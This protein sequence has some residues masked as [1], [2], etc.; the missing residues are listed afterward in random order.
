VHLSLVLPAGTDRA[1]GP[2]P[3]GRHGLSPRFVRDHQR[4]RIL[5]ATLEV[6]GDSGFQALTVDQIIAAAGVSRR[7]FYDHFANRDAAFVAAY[8]AVVDRVLAHV[9]DA[10]TEA[11]GFADRL[12]RGLEALVD[13]LVAEPAIARAVVVEVLAS[14]APGPA[15]RDKV[16]RRFASMLDEAAADTPPG[17]SRPTSPLTASTVVGGINEVVATRLVRGHAA[18]LPSLVPDLVYS[19]LLPYVGREAA[20]AE[21]RRLA[22]RA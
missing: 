16:L 20:A 21:H 15:R 7:T 3:A 2:L 12:H 18:E 19:A 9:G 11:D 10:C 14:S 6:A 13:V 22:G 1:A 5:L 8:D 17:R 4:E